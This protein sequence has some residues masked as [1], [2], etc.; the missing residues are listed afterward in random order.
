MRASV[1]RSH[2]S[3][4]ISATDGRFALAGDGL[5]IAIVRPGRPD[6]AIA[7]SA[8]ALRN[9]EAKLLEGL[10]DDEYTFVGWLSANGKRII[11]EHGKD[12]GAPQRGDSLV[13]F[14]NN[15]LESD[16]SS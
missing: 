2:V 11:D 10:P 5:R 14:K 13:T 4:L 8:A 1:K 16:P 12:L 9:Q 6:V 15:S 3:A 7:V